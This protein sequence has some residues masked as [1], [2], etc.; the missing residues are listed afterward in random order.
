VLNP[1][2]KVMI[3]K[4]ILA[5]T[6]TIFN[7]ISAIFAKKILLT[8]FLRKLPAFSHKIGENRVK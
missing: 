6:L 2:V 4:N 7:H 5:K 8:L 3:L 1:G